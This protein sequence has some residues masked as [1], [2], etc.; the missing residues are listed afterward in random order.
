MVVQLTAEDRKG[1][2]RPS[3]LSTLHTRDARGA[4]QIR[5]K[6]VL[7]VIGQTCADLHGSVVGWRAWQEDLAPRFGT[8]FFCRLPPTRR[9]LMGHIRRN[10]A[11]IATVAE[12]RSRKRATDEERA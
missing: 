12:A 3:Y 4:T 10:T 2:R 8:G 11:K 1:R 7:P 9:C 6:Y 5:I